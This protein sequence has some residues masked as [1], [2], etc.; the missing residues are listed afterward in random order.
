MPKVRAYRIGELASELD[1]PVETIR[2]YER[3]GLLPPPARTAGNYRLYGEK[4]R[5]RLAFVRNCRALDMTLEEV[6]ALLNVRDTPQ[7]NCEAVNTLL[8]Q[9]IEHVSDRIT[10]LRRLERQLRTLRDECATVRETRD[11]AILKG[12]SREVS[13]RKPARTAHVPRT[14][15]P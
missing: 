8:D 6:R 1:L 3:E 9:H 5:E 15:K 13:R 11:C 12:L 10:E 4:E 14:H 7:N 2:Y